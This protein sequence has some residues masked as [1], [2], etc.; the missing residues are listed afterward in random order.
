[1]S[2]LSGVAHSFFAAGLLL[3]AL[4]Q[5]LPSLQDFSAW[6][7]EFLLEFCINLRWFCINFAWGMLELFFGVEKKTSGNW[8]PDH[9]NSHNAL[10]L[11][12]RPLVIIPPRFFSFSFSDQ[13]SCEQDKKP[14]EFWE[15]LTQNYLP[16]ISHVPPWYAR[17]LR[18]QF[19][20]NFD[21]AWCQ[22]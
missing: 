22:R 10:V 21:F 8:T 5:Q 7:V 3:R 12:A 18:E 6:Y 15:V 14:K 20:I 17:F 11:T 19:F 4:L 1:M 13:I 9:Q 2:L 16:E